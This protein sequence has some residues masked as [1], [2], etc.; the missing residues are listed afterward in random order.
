VADAVTYIG[1]LAEVQAADFSAL[2]VLERGE[3]P[4]GPADAPRRG[5]PYAV[6][7]LERFELGT[8]YPRVVERV[9]ELFAG[10]PLAGGNL[11]VDQTGVGRPVVD[12]LRAA[13]PKATVRPITITAGSAVAPDGAGW[14]VPKKELVSVP[15]VLLQ[16]RRLQVARPCRTPPRWPASWRR[17]G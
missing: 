10:P 7:H 11:A 14:H 15:Q 16:S 9:V 6:R 2:A 12:T 3:P 1:G 8:P 4:G 17:S 13:R 5:R